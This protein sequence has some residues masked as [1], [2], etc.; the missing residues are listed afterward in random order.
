MKG[1]HVHSNGAVPKDTLLLFLRRW[2]VL[3]GGRQRR[4]LGDRGSLLLLLLLKM[5]LLWLL[6]FWFLHDFAA[7]SNHRRLLQRQGGAGRGCPCLH[8]RRAVEKLAGN[9]VPPRDDAGAGLAKVLCWRGAQLA[10]AQL[11]GQVPA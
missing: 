4:P 3:F 1:R 9:W 8:G 5:L 7:A 6:L 10:A 2:L 11:L